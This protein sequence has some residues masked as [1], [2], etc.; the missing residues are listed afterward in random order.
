MNFGANLLFA[1]IKFLWA[2]LWSTMLQVEFWSPQDLRYQQPHPI[3]SAFPS[4]VEIIQEKHFWLWFGDFWGLDQQDCYIPYI[5]ICAPKVLLP[6]LQAKQKKWDIKQILL[7]Y[8]VILKKTAQ[9]GSPGIPQDHSTQGRVTQFFFPLSQFIWKF[10]VPQLVLIQELFLNLI[11]RV[12]FF[13][14]KCHQRWRWIIFG[15]IFVNKKRLNFSS[16]CSVILMKS[17]LP[18]VWN[19]ICCIASPLIN[20]IPTWNICIPKDFFCFSIFFLNKQPSRTD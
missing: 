13:N 2:C 15:T 16:L 10:Q 19:F 5:L 1:I 11:G 7:Y 4:Y 8:N 14:A 3:L 6:M 18:Y 9:S 17:G 20:V 12:S